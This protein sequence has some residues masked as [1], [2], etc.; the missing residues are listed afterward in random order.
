M[1]LERGLNPPL[2]VA[3]GGKVIGH[4]HMRN[5]CLCSSRFNHQIIPI[6]VRHQHHPFIL[7]FRRRLLYL[8]LTSSAFV[9]ISACFYS[10]LFLSSASVT[11]VTGT[12]TQFAVLYSFF[13]ALSISSSSI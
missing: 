1:Y 11:L 4:G 12:A 6:R 10:L 5:C 7:F 2:R 3:I 8:F 13:I 9:A